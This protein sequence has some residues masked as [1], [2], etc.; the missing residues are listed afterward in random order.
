M[1]STD[2]LTPNQNHKEKPMKRMMLFLALFTLAVGIQA[3][4]KDKQ[5]EASAKSGESAG[6]GDIGVPECDEYVSKV[7][8]CV[9]DKVPET[10]RDM[11]KQ[12][13]QQN[14]SAWKQAASTPQGKEGLAMAC[15]SALDTVKQSMGAYGCEF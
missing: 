14:I 9:E 3:C 1:V 5:E 12:G 7:Q 2:S 10:A 4:S 13:F 6:A 11:V 8:K 15:K